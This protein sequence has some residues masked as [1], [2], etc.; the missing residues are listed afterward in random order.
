MVVIRTA[1]SSKAILEANLRHVSAECNPANLHPILSSHMPRNASIPE[2]AVTIAES[3]LSKVFR[4]IAMVGLVVFVAS[5]V[6]AFAQRKLG[7]AA[8]FG[9]LSLAA[10]WVAARR[11]RISSR[12]PKNT[13]PLQLLAEHSRQLANAETDPIKKRALIVQAEKLE[14]DTTTDREEHST[15]DETVVERLRNGGAM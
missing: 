12:E 9:L 11:H 8:G 15:L 7:L 2:R 14:H 4:I 6:S 13:G 5:S 10:F 1:E 3:I